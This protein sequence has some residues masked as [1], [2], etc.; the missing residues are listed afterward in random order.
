MTMIRCLRCR[1]EYHISDDVWDLTFEDV[2]GAKREIGLCGRCFDEMFREM[3]EEREPI[4]ALLIEKKITEW[5]EKE[6]K[7]EEEE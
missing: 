6:A 3:V 5:F 7:K 2:D 1:E 4:L